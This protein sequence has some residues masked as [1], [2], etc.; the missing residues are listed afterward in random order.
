[1]TSHSSVCGTDHTNKPSAISFLTLLSEDSMG[2]M[3]STTSKPLVYRSVQADEELNERYL[4]N[5]TEKQR[6]Y[7]LSSMEASGPRTDYTK[8]L[9]GLSRTGKK[10]QTFYCEI[11]SKRGAK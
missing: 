10:K 9:P 3:M 6:D 1:M 8:N 4:G 2:S 7:V 5:I 11:D